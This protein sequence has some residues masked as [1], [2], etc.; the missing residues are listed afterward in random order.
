M[1]IYLRQ[2]QIMSKIPW[3]EIKYSQK[4]T[5][6]GLFTT[7]SHERD[8]R[9]MEAVQD[10]VRSM[11]TSATVL[12]QVTG[13]M[14]P[15]VELLLEHGVTYPQ[16]AETLKA[17]FVDSAQRTAML[18]SSRITDSKIAITTGI[19]RKDVRRLRTAKDQAPQPN[20]VV[21]SP[22]PTS[23]VIT[24]WLTHASYCNSEG[25]PKPLPRS[26]GGEQGFDELVKSVS[27]DVHP[28]T[29]LDE[30]VR[31]GLVTLDNECVQLKV[32][33]FVPKPDFIQMINFLGANLHDHAA[34]AT[35][36]MLGKS[37]AFLE[38]SIYSDCVNSDA[39]SDLILLARQQWTRMLKEVVPE[40]AQHEVNIEGTSSSNE[41]K[42]KD[43]TRIRLGMYFFAEKPD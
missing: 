28:R 29:I 4:P 36:N 26:G 25:E 22:S 31:L 13:V 24:R 9:R 10:P 18:A 19:H 35:H 42:T 23:V 6:R 39:I 12:D 43:V 34:A 7:M 2:Y 15:L 41:D 37:P 32:D 27:T 14:G 11:S 30:L 3:P 17:V 33:S 16:L 20:N 21:T 38:Q 8:E 40:V 5:T 1:E